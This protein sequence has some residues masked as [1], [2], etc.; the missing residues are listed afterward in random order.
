MIHSSNPLL[1]PLTSIKVIFFPISHETECIKGICETDYKSN[2]TNSLSFPILKPIQKFLSIFSTSMTC[3]SWSLNG[4][5]YF[6][7]L[8]LLDITF[9]LSMIWITLIDGKQKFII[10]AVKEQFKKSF[11]KRMQQSQRKLPGDF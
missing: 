5:I 7:E 9:E 3:I 1:L 8:S 10:Y 4:S 2:K 11:K 6:I